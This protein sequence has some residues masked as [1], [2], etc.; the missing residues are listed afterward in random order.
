V[1]GALP[2]F[3]ELGR[4]YVAAGVFP[5]PGRVR[6]LANP[7]RAFTASFLAE[8]RAPEKNLL[9]SPA[10]KLAHVA[11]KRFPVIRRRMM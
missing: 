6:A 5:A 2:S 3:Q 11:E 8:G 10:E 7:G 1:T 9:D 4:R